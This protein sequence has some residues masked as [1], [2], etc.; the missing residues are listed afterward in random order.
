MLS[1]LRTDPGKAEAHCGENDQLSVHITTDAASE[2][3]TLLKLLGG[4][5]DLAVGIAVQ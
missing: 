3:H 1:P 5:I 4:D 2:A